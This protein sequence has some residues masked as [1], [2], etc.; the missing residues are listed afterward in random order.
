MNRNVDK[1]CYGLSY[2]PY[3]SYDIK[4]KKTKIKKE[5]KT[6]TTLRMIGG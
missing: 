4:P 3:Y 5:K 6:K 1:M 2:D